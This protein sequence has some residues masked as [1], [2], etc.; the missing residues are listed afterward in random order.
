[1]T[2]VDIDT[3]LIELRGSK[4]GFIEP[5]FPTIAGAGPNGAIIHYRAEEAT[6]RPVDKDTMLLLDSG[7]QYD[8]GTWRIYQLSVPPTWVEWSTD[9]LRVALWNIPLAPFACELGTTFQ[10]GAPIGC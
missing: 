9:G 10:M 6:A 1:M 5:S 2:E 8:C 4:P 7:A 3:K